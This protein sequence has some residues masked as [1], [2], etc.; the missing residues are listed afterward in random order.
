MVVQKNDQ[1]GSS[2]PAVLVIA[3]MRI[4]AIMMVITTSEKMPARASFFL[5]LI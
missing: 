5:S 1:D 2:W 3:I 4:V